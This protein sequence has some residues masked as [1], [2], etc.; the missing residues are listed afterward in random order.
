MLPN[1]TLARIVAEIAPAYLSPRERA[2]ALFRWTR[3]NLAYSALVPAER[4]EDYLPH[5]VL[6]RGRGYCVQKSAVL[7]A[8]LRQ[9][10]LHARLAYGDLRNHQTPAAL[11]LMLGSDLFVWHGW[12]EVELDGGWVVAE[13]AFDATW[14][15][16][17][18]WPLCELGDRL[19]QRDAQGRPLM[20]YLQPRGHYDSVPLDRIRRA[21]V[22]TYGEERIHR[23]RERLAR[24]PEARRG[25]A[26]GGVPPVR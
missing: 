21:W 7:F 6:A 5:V 26:A 12:V 23:W 20:S 4:P 16:R 10:G 14:C 2:T 17:F 8:L 22:E 15:H 25:Q 24:M 13:V 19:P 3:D 9:A 1:P 18:A 11:R